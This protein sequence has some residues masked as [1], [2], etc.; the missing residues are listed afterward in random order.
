MDKSIGIVGV[1]NMGAGMA[2]RL[3][4]CGWPVRACD[5]VTAK[6]DALV[7]Q[8]AT[9][10]TTP[11][12]AARGADALIVCVVDAAQA[13][14][15][16][17]GER[18]AVGALRHGAAVL[19]CSTIAPQEV[20]A[21]AAALVLQRLA[22][23]DAPMSGGP[24]RAR[25]GTMSLMVACEDDVFVAQRPL[26]DALSQRVFR[27]GTR[28]GDGARTKLVNN[29]LAAINLA[30][31]AEALALAERLGLDGAR[32]LD[33]IEQSSGQS[34]IGSDRMRRALAGDFVARAHVSLLHKDTRLALAAAASAGFPAQLGQLAHE[35]F[36]QAAAAGQA[37]L[38]DGVL[39]ELMRKS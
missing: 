33:V 7:A 4:A 8:G 37:D 38:D 32:T 6:V 27:V 14:D 31:A 12:D 22:P 30:G 16:L 34:W 28:C 3:L 39:L 9:A 18:G 35:V 24:A 29:L 21:L 1:G 17:F 19:L 25:D 2:A 11:A 5:L 36:A 20:E 15:V 13:Q 26:L 23:I 10:S